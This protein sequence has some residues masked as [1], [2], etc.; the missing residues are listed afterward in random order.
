MQEELQL[1]HEGNMEQSGEAEEARGPEGGVGHRA[2][3]P[4]C[5]CGPLSV[6][7]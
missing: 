2:S 6:S 7:P 4:A 3:L 1:D 5:P